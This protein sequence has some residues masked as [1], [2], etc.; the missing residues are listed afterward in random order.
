MS[1]LVS[2]SKR[3][4]HFT[5]AFETEGS[6]SNFFQTH[7]FV[8]SK[9]INIIIKCNKGEKLSFYFLEPGVHFLKN[10]NFLNKRK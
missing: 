9:K 10:D 2:A 1:G 5:L 8:S 3:S 4:A 7:R 6:F